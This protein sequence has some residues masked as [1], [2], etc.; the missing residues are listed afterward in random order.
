[1]VEVLEA[2]HTPKAL[3]PGELRRHCWPLSR[4]E[5]GMRRLGFS[6]LPVFQGVKVLIPRLMVAEFSVKVSDT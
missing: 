5:K 3:M 2:R 6:F 4:G 1:M